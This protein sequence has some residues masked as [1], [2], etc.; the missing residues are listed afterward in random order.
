M[1]VQSLQATAHPRYRIFSTFWSWLSMVVVRRRQ[2]QNR[3]SRAVVIAVEP[4]TWAALYF[5]LGERVFG[6]CLDVVAWMDQESG[7][8]ALVQN[9]KLTWTACKPLIEPPRWRS[10]SQSAFVGVFP[11]NIIRKMDKWRVEEL[12]NSIYSNDRTFDPVTSGEMVC[13]RTPSRKGK[14]HIIRNSVGFYREDRDY[15]GSILL[16]TACRYACREIVDIKRLSSEEPTCKT[17]LSRLAA[18]RCYA[19]APPEVDWWQ[20]RLRHAGTQSERR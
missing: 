13:L 10:S 19:F 12:R 16:S 15:D 18:E 6:S 17:C 14:A 20:G 9:P 4:G 8:V 3:C 2:T 11:I 7:V 1:L 5:A